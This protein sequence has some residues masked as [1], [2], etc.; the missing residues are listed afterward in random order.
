MREK[1]YAIDE[2]QKKH[3]NDVEKLQDKFVRK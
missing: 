3:S 1:R 2:E